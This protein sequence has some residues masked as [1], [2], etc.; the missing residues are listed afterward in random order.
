MYAGHKYFGHLSR[1]T[2][3]LKKYKVKLQQ[4]VCVYQPIQSPF[5]F[6]NK[7][8]KEAFNRMVVRKV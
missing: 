3:N 2:L 8:F 5:I 1:I 4:A 6:P 7:P